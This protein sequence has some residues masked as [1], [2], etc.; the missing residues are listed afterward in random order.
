MTGDGKPEILGSCKVVHSQSD[1][2]LLGGQLG[3]PDRAVDVPSGHAHLSVQGRLLRMAS[4]PRRGR[5]QR[6]RQAR[7]AGTKRRLAAACDAGTARG[8]STT[9]R[10]RSPSSSAPQPDIGGANMYA[11]DVDGD[12]MNDV[13]TSLH[14]HGYGLAWFKQGAGRHV[15]PTDDHEHACKR[16][17]CTTT[18]PSPSSTPL[19]LEDMDGDGLKDIVTGKTLLAHPYHHRRRRRQRA[20]EFSSSSSWFARPPCISS[21]T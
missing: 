1:L 5:R 12:G 21:L 11:Y 4:R 8:R 15:H 9:L 10:S 14:S 19:C 2:G 13:V 6:R 18:W 17:P 3:Q 16:W 20:G 7:P